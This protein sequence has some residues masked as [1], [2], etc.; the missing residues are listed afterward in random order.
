LNAE[1]E[2]LTFYRDESE[3][4]RA[5]AAV[6]ALRADMEQTPIAA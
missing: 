2:R 4:A 3:T 6:E 1:T 5:A